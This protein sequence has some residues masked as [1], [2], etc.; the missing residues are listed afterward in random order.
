MAGSMNVNPSQNPIRTISQHDFKTEVLACSQPVLVAFGATWSKPC[1]VLDT[2]LV[3]VAAAC[4][5][6]AKI[7][8]INA[9]DDPDLS[10][11]Y[12]IQ[13]IPTMLF[14]VGGR[15]QGRLVG[16]ATRE[17]ILGRLEATARGDSTGSSDPVSS[18]E[19]RS[20]AHLR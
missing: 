9:D 12:E 7:V 15:L 16:T 18:S 6:R 10:L 11:W 13:S 8:R 5:D 19:H 1:H 4:A 3:E 14:F 20:Q 17:A 2:V